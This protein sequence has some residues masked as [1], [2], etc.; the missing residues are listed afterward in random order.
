MKY[1]IGK[2]YGKWTCVNYGENNNPVSCCH[3]CGK[4]RRK[5]YRFEIYADNGEMINYTE[6]GTECVKQF[7][8]NQTNPYTNRDGINTAIKLSILWK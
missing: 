7:N 1:E 6:L 5:W 8:F 4:Y 2:Q 3:L